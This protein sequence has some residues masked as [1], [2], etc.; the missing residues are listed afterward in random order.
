MKTSTIIL[1]AAGAAVAVYLVTR[2]SS[3]LVRSNAS[4]TGL[5]GTLTGIGAAANGLSNLYDSVSSSSDSS[6]S[7]G[8]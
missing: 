3:T 6:V 1:I 4:P 7:T 2:Q 8:E 5:G